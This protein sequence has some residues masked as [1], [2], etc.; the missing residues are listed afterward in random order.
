MKLRRS[1]LCTLPVMALLGGCDMVVLNPSGY[2]AAQQRDVLV[3]S[4]LLMLLIIIPVMGLTAFFAWRYKAS[5]KARYDPDWHHS[6]SLELIIW[7]APL[8]IIICLGGLTWVSTHM[9]DPFRP[10]EHIGER[11]PVPADAKPLEVDVVALDWKWL[12]IYPE[13]GIATVNDA[14]A[15]VDRP[16][17]FKITSQSVM[18]AF[19]VPALAG[20]LYAMPGMESQVHAVMN[21]PGEYDGFSS[22]YSG[23]GFSHMRFKFH[24]LEPRDF[25]A[26]IGAA[27]AS[28]RTLDR[29]EYLALAEPSENVPPSSYAAVEPDLFDRVV[30]RC[31][32]QGRMCAG[33]M[34][35]LDGQGGTGLAGTV[36]LLP[37]PDQASAPFG[38]TPFHVAEL[39]AP[40]PDTETRRDSLALL[41]PLTPAPSGASDQTF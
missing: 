30:G 27:R 32:E 24:G 38:A 35:W 9:L 16:I 40:L 8:M 31:V 2:V 22:N 3:T 11:R 17:H 36:N 25:V 41:T 23:A 39:C 14:A 37:A 20:M 10:L 28:G 15:P 6:T 19:Y 33:E 18:N 4:T 5:R 13:Y 26:W 29:A 7:A 21:Y 34:A 1:L 12:F